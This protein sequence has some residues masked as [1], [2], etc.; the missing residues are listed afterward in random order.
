MK[1]VE[2]YANAIVANLKA[3]KLADGKIAAVVNESEAKARD[4]V[5]RVIELYPE[6]GHR[7]KLTAAGL[8]LFDET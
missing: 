6:A 7:W 1:T 4:I 3:G 8:V 2:Q 5:K